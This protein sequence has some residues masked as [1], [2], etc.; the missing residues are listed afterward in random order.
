MKLSI[1]GKR[2]EI[3]N[4]FQVIGS[5]REREN[6]FYKDCLLRTIPRTSGFQGVK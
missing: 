3:K 6:V 4:A 1:K 2:D 5:N